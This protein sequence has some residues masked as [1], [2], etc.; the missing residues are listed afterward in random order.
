MLI[1]SPGQH[2]PVI[3]ASWASLKRIESFLLLEE[4]EEERLGSSEKLENIY[5]AVDG[6]ELETRTPPAI[7]MQSASF[8]WAPD[9]EPFLKDITIHLDEPKLYMCAGPVASV[10]D[11]YSRLTVFSSANRVLGQVF[12]TSLHPWRNDLREWKVQQAIYARRLCVTGC[13]DR[14][15]DD[16]REHLVWT[17]LPC[18]AIF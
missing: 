9:T 14:T 16:S 15:G 5:V 3:A 4:R 12:T 8:S 17:R 13:Y 6:V 10:R 7:V 11:F 2:F 18:G 1:S